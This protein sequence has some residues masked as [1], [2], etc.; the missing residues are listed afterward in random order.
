VI[1]LSGVADSIRG[2]VGPANPRLS[3]PP[4]EVGEAPARPLTYGDGQTI[5]YG[6]RVLDTG[7]NFLSLDVSDDGVAFTT[8]DGRIWFTDGSAIDEIGRTNGPSHVGN[9]SVTMGLAGRPEHWVVSDNTGS[10]LAWTEYPEDI[11]EVVVY[12]SQEREVVA[13][14]PASGT[15]G[16]LFVRGDYVYWAAGPADMIRLEV[17]TGTQETISEQAYRAAQQSRPR[18]LVVGDSFESGRVTDGIGYD[19]DF[20]ITDSRLVPAGDGAE[21]AFFDPATGKRL[22]FEAPSESGTVERV[23]LFQW[24][25]D[26]RFALVAGESSNLAPTGELLVCSTVNGSCEIAV[27]ASAGSEEPLLPDLGGVGA[28]FA[29]RRAMNE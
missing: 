17:S 27:P 19:Q 2:E 16:P 12:D 3:D 7:L 22:R 25:D 18:T 26:Y 10:L 5:H 14:L 11:P 6:D 9:R 20:A 15:S 4:G 8:I 1:W 13:R 29:L 21:A 28:E 23:Y 24:L